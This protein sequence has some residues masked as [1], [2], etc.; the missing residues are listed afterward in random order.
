MRADPV[1]GEV[2]QGPL[3]PVYVYEAPVRLAHWIFAIAIV[4]L[5]ITGYLI[6]DPIAIQQGEAVHSFFFGWIRTIHFIA[7]YVLAITFVVRLYWVFVGNKSARSIFIPPLWSFRWWKGLFGQATYYLFVGKERLWVGHN[8]LAQAAMFF[9]FVLGVIFMILTGFALYAEQW[10][11]GLTPMNLF[12]WQ[13]KLLEQPQMVRT[14]HHLGMWYVL[15]FVMV[16]V[17]MVFREDIMSGESVI[18]TMINGIRMWKQK[19]KA[20]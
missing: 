18:G 9:M 11:W 2:L 17:Y 19:V 3:E 13:F 6:G 1:T 14:L 20:H 16:H 12:G 8:P 7:G 5:A 10:G 4:V 15:L